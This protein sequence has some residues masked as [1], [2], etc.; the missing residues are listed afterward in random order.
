[1]RKSMTCDFCLRCELISK[2]LVPLLGLRALQASAQPPAS[3]LT[4][5]YSYLSCYSKTL[6][7]SNCREGER[8]AGFGCRA[9]IHTVWRRHGS[10]NL[11]QLVTHIQ[12][13]SGERLKAARCSV[14]LFLFFSPGPPHMERYYLRLGCIFLVS[15][16]IQ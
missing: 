1:M 12:S 16:L 14:S 6:K 11:R 2:L 13:G 7:V 9:L 5:A 15:S 10:R 4:L 3:L 8:R